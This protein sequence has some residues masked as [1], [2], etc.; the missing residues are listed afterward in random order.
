MKVNIKRLSENAKLPERGSMSAA[1]YDLYSAE[2]KT[3][4]FPH[5]TTMIGTGLAA[6][7]PEGYFGAIFA[8]SGLAS[9]QG[10]RPANCVGVVDSDYRGEIKVALH[11]DTNIKQPVQAGERIA[12]LVVMPYLPVEFTEV[13]KLSDTVRGDGGFGSTGKA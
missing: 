7:I 12:Q 11:N 4:I 13:D 1:G 10:L 8:R 2:D 6:E 5:A 9:K 3:I